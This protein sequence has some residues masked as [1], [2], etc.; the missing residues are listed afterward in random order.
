MGNRHAGNIDRSTRT[1][2]GTEPGNTG[3]TKTRTLETGKNRKT[4]NQTLFNHPLL[5][6]APRI[7][8]IG[9]LYEIFL[10]TTKDPRYYI[11]YTTKLITL[12]IWRQYQE[13][14]QPGSSYRPSGASVYNASEDSAHMILKTVEPLA[15]QVFKCFLTVVK[16]VPVH[17]TVK[18]PLLKLFFSFGLSYIFIPVGVTSPVLDLV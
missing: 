17:V 9:D 13:F 10:R 5:Q 12:Y 15:F 8:T 14:M 11:F 2:G 16:A 3:T 18:K 6:E 4:V 7:I 1:R